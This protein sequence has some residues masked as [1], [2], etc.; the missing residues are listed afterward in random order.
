MQHFSIFLLVSDGNSKMSS[1]P[2]YKYSIFVHIFNPN[3]IYTISIGFINIKRTFGFRNGVDKY[4]KCKNKIHFHNLI[5]PGGESKYICWMLI[6]SDIIRTAGIQH[7][8]HKKLGATK[9][10]KESVLKQ[11]VV[12][13]N[14]L[15]QLIFIFMSFCFGETSDFFAIFFKISCSL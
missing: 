4:Q 8:T 14:C 12:T 1:T 9:H 13:I 11:A 6:I 7:V 5:F 10:I 2:K 3:K 15:L